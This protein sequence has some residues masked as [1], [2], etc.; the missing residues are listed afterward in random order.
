MEQ[1]KLGL[2]AVL[3]AEMTTVWKVKMLKIRVEAIKVS[4][5]EVKTCLLAE[6]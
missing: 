4:S 1:V 5:K 6:L 3:S 2:D